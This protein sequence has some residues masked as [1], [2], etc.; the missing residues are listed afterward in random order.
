MLS[1]SE[2]FNVEK[3]KLS[4]P[5]IIKLEGVTGMHVLLG[6]NTFGQ[7]KTEEKKYKGT[8]FVYRDTFIMGYEGGCTTP[9]PPLPC[10]MARKISHKVLNETIIFHQ[11]LYKKCLLELL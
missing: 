5:Q 2:I 3:L 10:D 1:E 6:D 11:E 9:P 7:M 4:V 8:L